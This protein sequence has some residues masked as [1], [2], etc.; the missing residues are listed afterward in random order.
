MSGDLLPHLPVVARAVAYG[1]G[2]PDFRPMLRRIRPW[3]RRNDLALCHVETPLVPGTPSG[4]PRFSSPPELA[5]AI[6][7]AG[8]D[9]CSTASNHS[10]D[11]GAHGIA[12]TRRALGRRGVRHTGTASTPRQARKLLLLRAKGVR[13]AFLAYTQHTNGLPLPH[14]WSVDLAAAGRIV[15]DARRARRAG[16]RAVIV[17]LHWGTEYQ[18]APDPF[19]SALARALARSG[20]ITAV[21]G[22]HAHVVQPIRRIGGM[23]VVFGEGNLLSNQTPACCAPRQPGRHARPAA[24]ARRRRTARASR[25][26]TTSR[27]GCA[28]P[29]TPSCARRPARRRGAAPS[30]VA[31]AARGLRRLATAPRLG[32][33]RPVPDDDDRGPLRAEQARI[34]RSWRVTARASSG[35]AAVPTGTAR[36]ARASSGPRTS[37]I[38]S[39]RRT[40]ARCSCW[41]SPPPGCASARAPTRRSWPGGSRCRTTGRSRSSRCS[42]TASPSSSC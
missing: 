30:A 32:D 2:R 8:F 22:Q 42:P 10:V 34:E 18:H 3:V 33:D 7:W 38:P 6:R 21:V 27:P 17:N 37:A 26:S 29:T 39:S 13:I 24:P 25:G 16:A 1:D 15:R 19:Q 4:Y 40:C 11:R 36:S 5:R 9:A 31:G 23:P 35:S 12:T 14:P 28:I 20:A 41:A